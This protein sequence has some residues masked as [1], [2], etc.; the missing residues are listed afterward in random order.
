MTSDVSPLQ[1]EKANSP[2]DFMVLGIV[3]DLISRQHIKVESPTDTTGYFFDLE[4]TVSGITRFAGTASVYPTKLA[5]ISAFARYRRL[6]TVKRSLGSA[7]AAK[8][9]NVNKDNKLNLKLFILFVF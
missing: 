1:Y 6:L 7:F 5:V 2:I 3:S 9:T 8:K 4:T